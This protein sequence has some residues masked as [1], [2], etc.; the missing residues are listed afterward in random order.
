MTLA[1][2]LQETAPVSL[3]AKKASR[4][5]LATLDAQL[6]L[7]VARGCRHYPSRTESPPQDP[8]L[9]RLP[10]DELAILLISGSQVYDPMAIRCAAQLMG[11]PEI[12]PRRLAFLAIK[13]KAQR[14]LCHIATAGFRHDPAGRVFWDQ[15]LDHLDPM[16][17][18]SEPELPHWTRFVSMQGFHRGK[19]A[20]TT[21]LTPGS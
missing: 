6:S 19:G 4:L 11:S 3:L 7:A 8:G 21:W 16:D 1:Q 14:P 2:V 12:D 18:R 10:N 17:S 5:G 13:E 20:S 9:D 15:V